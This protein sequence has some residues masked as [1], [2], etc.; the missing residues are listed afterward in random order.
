MTYLVATTTKDNFVNKLINLITGAEADDYAVT[1]AVGDRWQSIG[2]GGIAQPKSTGY[3]IIQEHRAGYW[4]RIDDNIITRDGTA[5]ANAWCRQTDVMGNWNASYGGIEI[6]IRVATTNTVAFDYSTATFNIA[7]TGTNNNVAT[8]ASN[9][10]V[11]ANWWTTNTTTDKPAVDGTYTIPAANIVSMTGM[12]VQFGDPSGF[13]PVGANWI[14]FFTPQALGGYDYWRGFEHA[15]PS[16]FTDPVATDELFVFTT[17]NELSGVEDTDWYVCGYSKIIPPTKISISNGVGNYHYT[18]PSNRSIAGASGM[19]SGIGYKTTTALTGDRY[20][21]K[22]KVYDSVGVLGWSTDNLS[23]LYKPGTWG[24]DPAGTTIRYG[25]GGHWNGLLLCKPFTT[26]PTGTST[27]QMFIS[28]TPDWLVV[29]MRTD[30]GF[31]GTTVGFQISR[32]SDED[33]AIQRGAWAIPYRRGISTHTRLGL[34]STMEI[35]ALQPKGYRDG[36]RDWQTQWGRS[37]FW[38]TTDADNGWVYTNRNGW[39]NIWWSDNNDWYGSLSTINKTIA[40]SAVNDSNSMIGGL[41]YGR[42][43]LYPNGAD[44]RF[45]AVQFYVADNAMSHGADSNEWRYNG[46]DQVRVGAVAPRGYLK[47][48]MYMT[49]QGGWADGDEIEETVTGDRSILFLGPNGSAPDKFFDWNRWPGVP[50]YYG[51]MLRQW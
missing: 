39:Q 13:L 3:E 30:A 22:F 48:A 1:C 29:I 28:V 49:S 18:P 42:N 26:T 4:A 38:T 19:S 50:T 31:G 5:M 21:V 12:T 46:T 37:D 23:I 41:P 9:N 51:I 47:S 44:N 27:I 14:R 36:G 7:W 2:N 10:W 34:H 40:S 15:L 11:G 8:T 43:E 17:G 20:E 16:D 35:I 6:T 33:P 32:I 24:T 25:F 45:K